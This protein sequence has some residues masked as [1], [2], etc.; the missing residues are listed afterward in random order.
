MCV[1]LAT[2]HRILKNTAPLTSF[3]A[4]AGSG[5]R[6]GGVLGV[7]NATW[8]HCSMSVLNID[9]KNS[10]RLRSDQ[11]SECQESLDDSK[12]NPEVNLTCSHTVGLTG[13]I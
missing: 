13:Q 1:P 5:G 4:P 2:A 7:A 6:R 12:G 3:R 8:V 11:G 10:T 9:D